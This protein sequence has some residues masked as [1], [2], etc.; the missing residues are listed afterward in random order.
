MVRGTDKQG[1]YTEEGMRANSDKCKEMK[2]AL[3]NDKRISHT[4]GNQKHANPQ[5]LYSHYK[6]KTF[7]SD[8][9]YDLIVG[10]RFNNLHMVLQPHWKKSPQVTVQPE[11]LTE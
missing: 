7:K 9:S 3:R 8:C 5:K 2:E 11:V 4:D 1:N 10:E 6:E